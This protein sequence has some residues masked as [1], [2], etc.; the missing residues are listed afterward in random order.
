MKQKQSK[1]IWNLQRFEWYHILRLR[2]DGRGMFFLSTPVFRNSFIFKKTGVGNGL[3]ALGSV[4]MEKPGGAM[5][6]N[7]CRK[8]QK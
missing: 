6:K 7:L 2:L 5:K 4:G 3:I 1:S 8:K